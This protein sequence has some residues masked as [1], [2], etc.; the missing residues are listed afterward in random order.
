MFCDRCGHEAHDDRMDPRCPEITGA[1]YIGGMPD[2]NYCGCVDADAL[3][4]RCIRAEGFIG[5]I[6]SDEWAAIDKAREAASFTRE[7]A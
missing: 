3:Y 7:V 2:P 4:A 6:T 1:T 5:R